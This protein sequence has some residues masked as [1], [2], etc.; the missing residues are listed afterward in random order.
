MMTTQDGVQEQQMPITIS[1]WILRR[2]FHF[3][4]CKVSGKT[5]WPLQKAYCREL[6]WGLMSDKKP[7]LEVEWMTPKSYTFSVLSRN[8]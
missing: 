5:I 1:D 8:N 4:K 6:F 2:D 7:E 3:R